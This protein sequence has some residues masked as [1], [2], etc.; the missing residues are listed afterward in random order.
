MTNVSKKENHQRQAFE[1]LKGNKLF[2][3]VIVEINGTLQQEDCSSICWKLQWQTMVERW[4]RNRNMLQ[5]GQ[6]EDEMGKTWW[7]VAKL[8]SFLVVLQR[9]CLTFKDPYLWRQLLLAKESLTDSHTSD[10][11]GCAHRCVPAGTPEICSWEVPSCSV[12]ESGD[13]KGRLAVLPASNTLWGNACGH[14]LSSKDRQHFP[15]SYSRE[16]WS[17]CFG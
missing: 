14:W 7:K 15:E 12:S 4:R 6:M 11:E 1:H 10:V 16:V 17:K 8:I 2:I 9:W 3:E 5:L 13:L